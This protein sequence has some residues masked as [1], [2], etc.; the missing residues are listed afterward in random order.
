MTAPAT[1]STRPKSATAPLVNRRELFC[2]AVA[3]GT[4]AA[5]AARRAG[6]SA[7]GAKQRGHFLMSQ[8]AVRLRVDQLRVRHRAFHKAELDNAAEIME[9]AIGDALDAKKPMQVM[10]AVEFRLKL[11]GVIQDRRI[12]HHYNDDR[13]SPDADVEDMPAD[14]AEWLDGLPAGL[15]ETPSPDEAQV[16]TKDDLPPVS[17]DDP[18]AVSS[19]PLPPARVIQAVRS[20]LPPDFIRD[21]PAGMLDDL[22]DGMADLAPA[23]LRKLTAELVT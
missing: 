6:Y 12:A 1:A 15:D 20:G 23:Q 14:P 3:A 18:E 7:K 5:E 13:P 4:S 21:L 8:A 19:A 22:C 2:E 10:R 17:E 9:I 11:I 16:V